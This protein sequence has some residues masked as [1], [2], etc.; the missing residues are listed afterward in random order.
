[1]K[2]YLHRRGCRD[3]PTTAELDNIC[4][5]LQ[6]MSSEQDLDPLGAILAN[7]ASLHLHQEKNPSWPRSEA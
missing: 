4:D 2:E 6:T 7:M 5:K 1:M 3:N